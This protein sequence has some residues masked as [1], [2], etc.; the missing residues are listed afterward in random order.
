VSD[1]EPSR[2]EWRKS[3]ASSPGECAEVAFVA[4]SVL[5]RHSQRPSGPV[6]TFSPAEWTA[7]LAGVRNGE[8]D[9]A[10]NDPADSP[11]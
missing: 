2:A 4:G 7:F 9:L 8:F 5:M 11:M 1:P 3:R 6:L 10:G